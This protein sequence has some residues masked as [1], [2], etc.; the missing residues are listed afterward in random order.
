M[1]YVERKS[2]RHFRGHFLLQYKGKE[3][4]GEGQNERPKEET[5]VSTNGYK[6]ETKTT[7]FCRFT[8]KRVREKVSIY[9]TTNR[10]PSRE[11]MNSNI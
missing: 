2:E 6:K 10:F 5:E 11:T 8:R 3:S 1:G 7:T 4:D 9:R